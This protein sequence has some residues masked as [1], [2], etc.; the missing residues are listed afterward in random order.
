[1]TDVII[2]GANGKMGSLTN[3]II[4]KINS[5]NITG[6]YDPNFQNSSNNYNDKKSLPDADLVIDFCS[7]D[8]IF[9]NCKYW[10]ENYKNVIVGASGL[11]NKNIDEL[12]ASISDTLL[13][14]VPNFSI[15]SVL[16]KRWSLEA[17]EYFSNINIEERHHSLK[18]D[19]PSGTA[20]DL[21]SDLN[22]SSSNQ[23]TINTT[24]EINNINNI[25][26][27]SIRDDRYLAEHEVMFSNQHEKLI[28]EHIS[29]DRE[30]YEKGIT[31]AL[32]RYKDLSGLCIG[33][34]LILGK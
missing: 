16:Q 3:D 15:G 18:Q 21:A 7:A 11:T 14:I 13:W 8:A 22:S 28:I 4:A 10:I 2:S 30:S 32:D 34:D 19:S 33:L 5:F 29:K 17:Q 23:V 1:M 20:Y 6:L 31:L 27:H 24:G 12:Q 25:Q 26:I 9:E